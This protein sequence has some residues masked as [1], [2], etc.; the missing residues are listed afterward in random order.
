MQ[1][2]EKLSRGKFMKWLGISSAF[3]VFGL[4]LFTKKKQA[5]KTV[6]MLTEDGKLV[7]IDESLLSAPKRKITN[8]ELRSWVKN[9]N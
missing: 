6:R 8:D 2:G 3:T 9:K 1:N 5:P 7:E 4:T